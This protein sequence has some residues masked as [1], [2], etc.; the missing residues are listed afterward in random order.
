MEETDITSTWKQWVKD[1]STASH[2]T[3]QEM[4]V[5]LSIIVHMGHNQKDTLKIYWLTQEQPYTTIMGMLWKVTFS[6]MYLNS[7]FFD[8]QKDPDKTGD[9]CDLL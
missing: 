9:T 2:V 5:F 6:F 3:V 1:S 4:Y 7:C 8:N